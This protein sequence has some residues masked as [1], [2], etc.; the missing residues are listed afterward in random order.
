[1]TQLAFFESPAIEKPAMREVNRI[2]NPANIGWSGHPLFYRW[3]TMVGRCHNQ[4]HARFD[5]YGAR[6]IIVCE[7]WREGFPFFLEDMGDS[8]PGDGY[9]I[10]RIDPFGPYC[11]K[12]CRWI[13]KSQNI[14]RANRER[15]GM[16]YQKRYW[17]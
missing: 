7:R 6:G 13:R 16:R 4:N 15:F 11:K 17:R 5:Q 8:W 9:E 1:M 2:I 3:H 10:D 12:N 14:A